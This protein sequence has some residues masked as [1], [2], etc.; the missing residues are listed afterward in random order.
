MSIPSTQQESAAW[1]PKG[2]LVAAVIM[3]MGL[4]FGFI[5]WGLAFLGL[6][7]A[8]SP[9]TASI[10]FAGQVLALGIGLVYGGRAALGALRHGA[11]DIDVLMF[12]GALLAAIV[13]EVADGALLLFLFTL[14]GALEGLAME[15]TTRAIEALSKLMPTSALRLNVATGAWEKVEPQLL[16]PGD[17]VRILPGE[18]IPADATLD[19]G[20]TSVNQATLTGE[21]MPRD[22]AA[23]DELFAGTINVGNPVEATVLRPAGESSLQRIL[24]LVTTAQQQREPVQQLLD[25]L[26]QPYAI[27]VL[28]MSV[29]AF[30]GFWLLAGA[31]WR[32]SL[33][34]GITLLIVASPCALIIATPTATLAAISRGARSGVLFKGG[35][36]IQRLAGL[37]AIAFDKTGTLTV[38]KPRV[39]QVHPVAWS[40]GREVLAIAAGLEAHSTHPIA[41]AIIAAAKQRGVAPVEL[42]EVGYVAGRGVSGWAVGVPASAELGSALA[43][44]S[45]RPIEARLGSLA[46]T[47]ELIPVCLRSRV[48]ELLELVQGRGQIAVVCAYNEQAVVFILSDTV[49]P[50]A[51]CL[52]TRLHELG[53]RP[54]VMLTGDNRLTAARVGE[55][56]GLD[57]VHAELLPEHKVE[58]VRALRTATHRRESAL[59]ETSRRGKRARLRDALNVLRGALSVGGDRGVG[60]IGDGVN[61]VPALAASD[62]SIAI[63]SIG[64][65][66]ALES[67]DIVLLSDD[68]SAVPWAVALARRTR[69]TI[70]INL[71]FAVSAM[72][73][74]AVTVIVSKLLGVTVPMWAGVVGHEGG[75]LLVVAHSLLLLVYPGVPLCTCRSHA[76]GESGGAPHA[77]SGHRE[78]SADAR[79]AGVDAGVDAGSRVAGV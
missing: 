69:R 77:K 14:S 74:M 70:T 47:S 19:A 57:E 62:V 51:E 46:H 13:G 18:T 39:N 26:S 56:L 36:S 48:R 60:V 32:E 58:H 72:L 5:V 34:T 21:S 8:S 43:G 76:A 55:A 20:S 61:D 79:N 6:E 31:P 10:V 65:D 24:D 49:R 66:A 30:L 37:G 68:L 16:V 63:G 67:A 22:V 17:R 4:S 59:P 29:M 2:E 27:G 52:V 78:S 73:V 15:R 35:Q 64:S 25:R 42:S 11:F 45:P 44:Q 9:L 33:Y 41:E 23:G 7:A 71:L 1:S 54:V 28:I 12:L 40:H 3:G 75:T 38:G 50:G 53:V